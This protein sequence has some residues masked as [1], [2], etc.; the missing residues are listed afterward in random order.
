MAGGNPLL[1]DF[2]RKN[3]T[4]PGSYQDSRYSPEQLER[5]YNAP[6]AGPAQTGR[7]SYD[8]SLIHI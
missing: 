8:L 7:M 6:A 1:R 5:M 3:A 4:T 2:D